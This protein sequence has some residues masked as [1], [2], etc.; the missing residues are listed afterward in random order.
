MTIARSLL[1]DDRRTG[2]YHLISRCVRR[3]YLCGGAVEHRREWVEQGIQTQSNAFA[4]DVL[5]FCVMSNHMHI[6]LRTDP[7][8]T[9]R[10]SAR[11][12]V[13]RWSAVFSDRDPVTGG[14][15]AWDPTDID[16]HA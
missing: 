4:V 2:C 6:I 16:R 3:A 14:P 8:Q 1:I 13:E 7:D 9:Q 10:W 5:S 11:E 15:I 12:V